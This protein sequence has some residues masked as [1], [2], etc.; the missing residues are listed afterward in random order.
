MKD[1]N[2]NFNQTWLKENWFKIGILIVLIIVAVSV[3]KMSE[4]KTKQDLSLGQEKCQEAGA[5]LDAETRD[6]YIKI[7]GTTAILNLPQTQYI[8]SQKMNTCVGIEKNSAENPQSDGEISRMSI[9]LYNVY[10]TSLTFLNC[11]TDNSTGRY[12]LLGE[13][14]MGE[15][16]ENMNGTGSGDDKITK[17]K[18]GDDAHFWQQ[19]ASDGNSLLGV[20]SFNPQNFNE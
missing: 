1:F 13:G 18:I 7:G 11:R 15:I 17:F 14:M 10:N 9:Q 16:T 20:S 3:Y 19:C 12:D 2:Q 8:Y 4:L 6:N 5:K